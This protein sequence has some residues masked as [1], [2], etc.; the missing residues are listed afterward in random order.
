MIDKDFFITFEPESR[1]EK[2]KID[3]FKEDCS[4]YF[5]KNILIGE[6]EKMKALMVFFFRHFRKRFEDE[7]GTHPA[8]KEFIDAYE[9]SPEMVKKESDSIERKY[10]NGITM[11]VSQAKVELPSQLMNL[12]EVKSQKL[13]KADGESMSFEEYISSVGLTMHKAEEMLKN[14]YKIIEQK[15][16]RRG[17]DI[18][19][20]ALYELC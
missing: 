4:R 3:A 16:K 12:V 14:A 18:E 11:A 1:Y 2:N 7:Y 19:D 17:F 20:G 10:K 8:Y 13:K 9:M 5:L 15:V 6:E